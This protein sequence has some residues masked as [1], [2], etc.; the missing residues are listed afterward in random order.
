MRNKRTR[1]LILLLTIM[2][3]VAMI[4]M[5]AC[6]KKP[7]EDRDDPVPPPDKKMTFVQYMEKLNAG[8]KN[9]QANLAALKDYHVK[10]EYTLMT[11]EENL[12]LTYE[13]VYKTNKRD[14][15]YYIKLFDNEN[16]IDRLTMYYDAADLYVTAGERHYVINN[17][18]TLL[19]FETFA[20]A[21]DVLDMGNYAYGTEMQDIFSPNTVLSAVM[22]VKNMSYAKV[23]EKGERITASGI[24]L[25]VTMG[26]FNDR[27]AALNAMIG[28]TFD[29][30][31]DNYL[32]FRLSKMLI[33][34][35]KS[36]SV[37]EASFNLTNGDV[38]SE[39]IDI[40]GTID[41][42][43]Y[44]IKGEYAHDVVV[45]EIA[46]AKGLPDAYVY[47]KVSPGKGSLKGKTTIPELRES[48]FDFALDYDVVPSDN[49]KNKVTMRVYDDLSVSSGNVG[50]KKYDD[51]NEII[52]VY[53]KDALT[54]INTKGAYDFIGTTVALGALRLPK[55]YLK[56]FDLSG[57]LAVVYADLLRAADKMTI[58][59][60]INLGSKAFE[61]IINAVES[62]VEK[63]EIKVTVTE[64]LVRE[65]RGE[66]KSLLTIMSEQT[67]IDEE[68]LRQYLGDDFFRNMRVVITYNFG[69]KIV[70]VDVYD[71]TKLVIS[72]DLHTVENVGVIF[73]DDLNELNYTEFREPEL[74]TVEYEIE[75]NPYG[76]RNVS[77]SEFVGSFIGDA[78]GKNT[79]YIISEGHYVVAKGKMSERYVVGADGKKK[80]VT[81]LDME[82]FLEDKGKKTTTKFMSIVSDSDDLSK[83]FIELYTPVGDSKNERGIAYVMSK[84]EVARSLETLSENSIFAGKTGLSAFLAIYNAAE[85]NAK[86]YTTD[87]FFCVDLMVT[88]KKDPVNELVGI[89]NT[90]ARVKCK[91]GF[92]PLDLSGVEK[93]KYTTPVVHAPDDASATSIYS[94]GSKWKETVAVTVSDKRINMRVTYDPESI[95]IVT[96]KTEYNPVS[97][98]FGKEFGYALQ[99]VGTTGTYRVKNVIIDREIIDADKNRTPFLV[100]DPAFYSGVPKTIRVMFEGGE[101]G[102]LDCEIEGLEDANVTHD[103]YNL[104]LFAE[105]TDGIKKYKLV[106]GKDSIASIEKEIY[107]GVVNRTVKP[108]TDNN[109]NELRLVNGEEQIPVVAQ[110]VADPYTHAM[111]KRIRK[112]EEGKEYDYLAENI[113]LQN[114]MLDFESLYGY[115]SYDDGDGIKKRPLYYNRE[116]YNY[117]F[118]TELGLEWEF[119]NANELTDDYFYYGGETRYAVATYGDE[120]NG[121]GVKIAIKITVNQMEV[122]SVIIDN[123]ENTYV[124]DVLKTETYDI[125]TVTST[126]HTVKIKFND[127]R[128]TTRIVSLSRPAGISTER[129][130]TEYVYGSL[131]WAGR[132]KAKNRLNLNGVIGL[133]GEEGSQTTNTT[134]ATFGKELG[135]SVQ[136]VRLSVLA[137]RRTPDRVDE[138]DC[139]LVKSMSASGEPAIP[140]PANLNMVK[141]TEP[142]G[143]DKITEIDYFSINP[144]NKTARLPDRIWLYL[145]AGYDSG[146]K[147]PKEWVEYPVRWLTTDVSGKELNIIKKN[148]DGNFVLAHPRT[149]ETKLIVYGV[150]GNSEDSKRQIIISTALLNM[151]SNV[152]EYVLYLKNGGAQDK[153]EAVSID[154]YLSYEDVLPSRF[155]AKLG[156]GETVSGETEWYYGEFPVYRNSEYG[157]DYKDARYDKYYGKDGYYLFDRRGGQAELKMTVASGAVKNDIYVMVNVA[158]R[159]IKSERDGDVKIS[160]YID[161]FAT[162]KEDGEVYNGATTAGYPEI[163]Y[164]TQYSAALHARIARLIE[165]GGVGVAGFSFIQ[166]DDPK[167]LYAKEVRWDLGKLREIERGLT[168]K[169]KTTSFALTGTINS[170]TINETAISVLVSID[171]VTST[172]TEI[173]LVSGETMTSKGVYEIKNDEDN[174]GKITVVDG[175]EGKQLTNAAYYRADMYDAY[176]G[177]D[178]K[179]EYNTFENVLFFDVSEAFRLSRE[180]SGVYAAPSDYFEYLFRAVRLKFTSGKTIVANASASINYGGKDAAYFNKNVLGFGDVYY[181][182][183]RTLGYGF[184]I[185]ERFS[186]GS[187][188]DR[189]LVIVAADKSTVDDKQREDYIDALGE[190]LNELY[191]E[192]YNLPEKVTVGFRKEDGSTYN[193]TYAVKEWTPYRDYFSDDRAAKTSIPAEYINII[194]GVDY[195]FSYVLPDM[196]GANA[197]YNTFYYNVKFRKKNVRSIF[198]DGS[199]Q[200]S[201]YDIKE[202]KIN[203]DNT[204]TFLSYDPAATDEK[205]YVVNLSAI[206]TVVKMI[207]DV[208]N[209]QA[210]GSDIY[211][212]KWNFLDEEGNSRTA[213]DEKIF[214]QGT[215]ENGVL[216]ATYSF[217]S[218]YDSSRK[219]VTQTLELRLV[220]APMRFYAIADENFTVIAHQNEGE[221][222]LLNTIVIDP[223]NNTMGNNGTLTL[224]STLTLSFNAGQKFKFSN[225]SYGL[226]NAQGTYQK[227]IRTIGYNENGHK[228]DLAY[229]PDPTWLNLRVYVRGYSEEMGKNN[230]IRINI[231]FLK[232]NITDT[233]IPNSV[234]LSDGSFDYER[235]ANGNI[236]YNEN[237]PLKKTYNSYAKYA[238]SGS[239]FN[240]EGRMPVYFVDPYNSA[241]FALPTKALFEFASTEAGVYVEYGIS[242]WQYYNYSKSAYEDFEEFKEGKKP[243]SFTRFY[244]AVDD[245]N[246]NKRSY[247][248]PSTDSY[249][250]QTYALRGYVSVGDERQYFDVVMV[251]LNRSLRTSAILKD[252]YKVNYDFIDPIAAMLKDIPQLFGENAFVDY[253]R[254]TAKFSAGGRRTYGEGTYDFVLEEGGEFSRKDENGVAT[255]HAIV[256]EMLW[257]SEYD[258]DGDGIPDTLF[259]QLV[260]K[261]FVG[262]IDGNLYSHDTGI[263][264]LFKYYELK[265]DA[266]Y[267]RLASALL[268][269]ELFLANGSISSAYS[270]AARRAI[271]NEAAELEKEVIF[272]TY[273]IVVAK[274]GTSDEIAAG[275]ALSEDDKYAL[276]TTVIDAILQIINKED[277][278]LYDKNK[279]EDMKYLAYRT[280]LATKDS[281][282][283]WTETNGDKDIRVRIYEAW[284]AC[285]KEYRAADVKNS[286]NISANQKAKAEHFLKIYN[287]EGAFNTAEK[288]ALDAKKK[289]IMASL[290]VNRNSALWDE[291]YFAANPVER[292]MM[293]RYEKEYQTTDDDGRSGKSMASDFF[294]RDVSSLSDIGTK[295]E[296][297]EAD[298]SIP[299]IKYSSIEVTG[300]GT[301]IRFNKFNFQSIDKTFTVRFELSYDEIYKRMLEEAEEAVRSS[302]REEMKSEVLGEYEIQAIKDRVNA[303]APKKTDKDGNYYIIDG[304]KNKG[305]K[306]FDYDMWIKG[307]DKDEYRDFW[308][309]LIKHYR[310]AA[311]SIIVRNVSVL[312][313]KGYDDIKEDATFGVSVP[314]WKAIT[315][316]FKEVSILSIA[317]GKIADVRGKF[318]FEKQADR[319][320]AVRYLATFVADGLKIT[321]GDA[322]VKLGLNAIYATDHEYEVTEEIWT[323]VKAKFRFEAFREIALNK[324]AYIEKN[325]DVEEEK[326]RN[327]AVRDLA[328]YLVESDVSV[329]K[330][331]EVYENTEK[332]K[333]ATT[334]ANTLLVTTS[335]DEG[336]KKAARAAASEVGSDE[337]E[338]GYAV[339]FSYSYPATVTDVMYDLLEATFGQSNEAFTDLCDRHSTKRKKK[340]IVAYLSKQSENSELRIAAETYFTFLT[341]YAKGKISPY[342]VMMKNPTGVGYAATSIETIENG[343]PTVNCL[344][345]YAEPNQTYLDAIKSKGSAIGMTEREITVAMKR[346]KLYD[347]LYSRASQQDKDNYYS[348]FEKES[349]YVA[350]NDA[351]ERLFSALEKNG[352]QGKEITAALVSFY[353]KENQKQN[354]LAY[355]AFCALV[356]KAIEVGTTDGKA[357]ET[358]VDEYV[359]ENEHKKSKELLDAIQAN[360]DESKKQSD[361]SVTGIGYISK[362]YYSGYFE[363]KGYLTINDYTD[364]YHDVPYLKEELDKILEKKGLAY[365]ETAKNAIAETYMKDTLLRS[366]AKYCASADATSRATIEEVVA[367]FTGRRIN[368]GDAET[369]FIALAA[370]NNLGAE[371]G[372]KIY[373]ALNERD[374][375]DRGEVEKIKERYYAEWLEEAR[376]AAKKNI[377]S[378]QTS[379]IEKN[380]AFN[381]EISRL[382]GL[383]NV[384][385]G[386]AEGTPLEGG[387]LDSAK[388]VATVKI[389]AQMLATAENNCIKYNAAYN[390][391]VKNALYSAAKTYAYDRMCEVKS[392]SGNYVYRAALE[393]IMATKTKEAAEGSGKQEFDER[394]FDEAEQSMLRDKMS[395]AKNAIN[396]AI[397]TALYAKTYDKI[398]LFS[399]TANEF[400]YKL[401]AFINNGATSDNAAAELFGTNLNGAD[402]M[403]GNTLNEYAAGQAVDPTGEARRIVNR[404]ADW[405]KAGTAAAS[406]YGVLGEEERAFIEQIYRQAYY[407]ANALAGGALTSALSAEVAYATM[408]TSIYLFL[409]DKDD[410]ESK[411]PA[412]YYSAGNE[413]EYKAFIV[414]LMLDG[415]L[416]NQKGHALT[417]AAARLNTVVTELALNDA[418]LLCEYTGTGTVVG[419][420]TLS[421]LVDV[422]ANVLIK[423]SGVIKTGEI[424]EEEIAEREKFYLGY[425]EKAVNYVEYTSVYGAEEYSHSDDLLASNPLHNYADKIYV[426]V[427]GKNLYGISRTDLEREDEFG[428]LSFGKYLEKANGD[429]S[430]ALELMTETRIVEVRDF[431]SEDHAEK[432]YVHVVYFDRLK[433]NEDNP[434]GSEGNNPYYDNCNVFI[435]NDGKTYRIVDVSGGYGYANALKATGLKYTLSDF[436][437]IDLYF[438][439]DE[440]NP[441][442]EPTRVDDKGDTVID[443]TDMTKYAKAMET[444]E[445]K[446]LLMLDALAPELPDKAYAIGYVKTGAAIDYAAGI[447]LGK[448]DITEY[449]QEFNKLVYKGIEAETD[450]AYVIKVR[451]AR[452][453]VYQKQG[454]IRVGYLDRNVQKVYLE[455]GAYIKGRAKPETSGEFVNMYSQYDETTG[456]ATSGKNVI[457]IDPTNV[458]LVLSEKKS[459]AMPTA[460]TVKCGEGEK[461]E[462]TD[463]VWDMSKVKFGLSGTDNKGIDMRVLEYRY[464]DGNGNTRKIEYDYAKFSVTMTTYDKDTGEEKRKDKYELS[465][466]DMIDWNTV[467]V[468]ENQSLQGIS[469][470]DTNNTIAE[471]TSSSS[472]DATSHSLEINP[473]YPEYPEKLQLTL[474]N[475]SKNI[476]LTQSDWA[477]DLTKLNNI[478]RGVATDYKFDASFY[479]L[480][481]EIKVKFKAMEITVPIGEMLDGGTIY[482]MRDG[483]DYGTQFKRNYGE[484][485]FNFAKEEEGKPN[486]QKVPVALKD[487]NKISKTETGIQQVKAVIGSTSV[488]AGIEANVK[489]NLRLIDLKNYAEYDGG[490]NNFVYYDYYSIPSDGSKKATGTGESPA[491]MGDTFLFV[492]SD[493]EKAAFNAESDALQ[494]D[495]I[496]ST[497]TVYA[498]YGIDKEADAKLAYDAN[499][500]RKRGLYFT[501]PMESYER[502][503]VSDVEFVT[504]ATGKKW[505]WTSKSKTSPDYVD[506]IYWKIGTPMKASDLPTIRDRITGKEIKLD[507]DLA[508]LNV[509]RANVEVPNHATTNDGAEILGYYM[510][511][512]G[513]WQSVRLRVYIEKI[514]ITD[515]I[516]GFTKADG[517]KNEGTTLEKEYNAQYYE[518]PFNAE[519]DD[520]AFLREDGTHAVIPAEN[521]V[522]EYMK[523]GTD[524]WSSEQL[525]LD[526]GTY[527]IRVRLRADDYNVYIEYDN[528]KLFTLTIKPYVVDMSKVKFVGEDANGAINVVY[529]ASNV[530]TV[531]EGLPAFTPAGWFTPGEKSRLY[532]NYVKDGMTEEEAKAEVYGVIYN[533]VAD[534]TK[535][536]LDAWYREGKAT[537]GYDRVG[538]EQ[539]I[540]IKAWIYDSK[541]DAGITLV[542]IQVR[543]TYYYGTEQLDYVP[544]DCGNYTVKVNLDKDNANYVE[545]EKSKNVTLRIERDENIRYAFATANLVYNGRVQNPEISDLHKDG[546]VPFGVK[547]T[548]RYVINGKLL[549]VLVEG[550]KDVSGNVVNKITVDSANTTV[551]NPTSGIKNAGAYICS[552]EIDGGNNYPDGKINDQPIGISAAK[553]FIDIAD[554]NKKYLSDVANLSEYVKVYD[555]DGNEQEEGIL[556][557]GDKLADLGIL[558]LSAA[559]AEGI[560]FGSYFKV[561]TY[562]TFIDGLASSSTAAT[563]YTELDSAQYGFN[564]YIYSKLALKSYDKEGSLYK[565]ADGNAA[566]ID[567]F[568]NYNIFVRTHE[569][570][571]GVKAAGIYKVEGEDG[572]DGVASNAELQEYIANLKDGDYKIV[573]LSSLIDA[574]GNVAA[575]DP[576]VID[577]AVR[578]KI[579]GYTKNGGISESGIDVRQIETKIKGIRVLKGIVELRIISI[580]SDASGNS[581]LFIGDEASAV[582]MYNCRITKSGNKTDNVTGVETSVNY[583]GSVYVE[584]TTIDNVSMA[585]NF[586]G[587]ALEVRESTIERNYNG[588][589]ISTSGNNVNIAETKFGNNIG[590]AITSVTGDLTIR[591]CRF[592]YNGIS[593]DLPVGTPI[594]TDIN[595]ANVYENNGDDSLYE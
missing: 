36:C 244:T 27:F 494:Y 24:N 121:S 577:K 376:G 325:N 238:F 161:I 503:D 189:T 283:R 580:E 302:Y 249:K 182:T 308:N 65:L 296:R 139:T 442:N 341:R 242:G 411:V 521:Y 105:K 540:K 71:G 5:I 539:D 37:K 122:K 251:V 351:T 173:E 348:V 529:G 241:T 40:R 29:A 516:I 435:A 63:K 396:L 365:G 100:I 338:V 178:K 167:V 267:G 188:L 259:E 561:G 57:F 98:L 12:T 579:V 514:N 556:L 200:T 311:I 522:V 253:D 380:A 176:F 576:I 295:G 291:V 483:G 374:D 333:R 53:Y 342:D 279:E 474:A 250:G 340:A 112:N 38:H 382:T 290:Y 431:V 92:D 410:E 349:S 211:T 472:A 457:Y 373:D 83:V 404:L 31:T 421:Q 452:G 525:P 507:W 429:Y 465:K 358:F 543:F 292:E 459:Y 66:D 430:L 451:E 495:F 490:Y 149:D 313:N 428:M 52:S 277:Q 375:F 568:G 41:E 162:G 248:N 352:E 386:K 285:I 473:Y 519:A 168:K 523:E 278:K 399:L 417:L 215:D 210:G 408:T 447:K 264:A 82:F 190:D 445:K 30:I 359:A 257:S 152:K 381:A 119:I 64:D 166:I 129:Y 90:N 213:F 117:M 154:P 125:P 440:S 77:L 510:I 113:V 270:D 475:G 181:E 198:F 287:K 306:A 391:T 158:S 584:K 130:C 143:K 497:V 89:K 590:T 272:A 567:L 424:T 95:K 281:Y 469:D 212:V 303:I 415:D 222:E 477:P 20:S 245:N 409:Q 456:N 86:T 330:L 193:S 563:T 134:T 271:Q 163:S 183:G 572:S 471:A 140:M 221:D 484:M 61:S 282:D 310:D 432:G 332:E 304:L 541:M 526:A 58:G 229:T 299:V 436:T 124:M 51:I 196:E 239:G 443:Y 261:G 54:Y 6:E 44:M 486:W 362:N 534:R 14:G 557:G 101:Y 480:G 413:D 357:Y 252:E 75:L 255:N 13:A 485:Y 56:N 232:R 412:D 331:E 225:V 464:V 280:Y 368:G 102:S 146:E 468:I 323:T 8:I 10:S 437:E 589:V 34:K 478:R 533:R 305:G 395:A 123:K 256:P 585:I 316:A 322:Y 219:K 97:K 367:T 1:L 558:R 334:L 230:G 42:S 301:T 294:R 49:K 48:D 43:K 441:Y 254:Y 284:T 70:K 455:T 419:S 141:F 32:G 453:T 128:E 115:E 28:T 496:G 366:I 235:D 99:I 231:K 132:E 369:E 25:E 552:V 378:T 530:F 276:T 513:I 72:T 79:P 120:K 385:S 226:L 263:K 564:G 206:P 137:P 96:G 498:T 346:M 60:K 150:V 426:K 33:F 337:P 159:T 318:D 207:A 199:G 466:D 460:M 372:I 418:K 131:E 528:D 108:V 389:R 22:G 449:S 204:Y 69:T 151:E 339:L 527:Y 186:E 492:D 433:W 560:T 21:I 481:Y 286:G 289:T 202:G 592:E 470:S 388:E 515:H 327:K 422:M 448:V 175:G 548:Y 35:L 195:T 155:E 549:V 156:S 73:P 135:M 509:N 203:V 273:K 170:D 547:V 246:T 450:D 575:Y 532:N 350:G 504:D 518:L 328:E 377:Q 387:T 4:A 258:T 354:N 237:R 405:W 88:E 142:E 93:E 502:S 578:L 427:T 324:L 208:Q 329:S 260:N 593:L 390:A 531:A 39:L 416:L 197:T 194:D 85:K 46:A 94:N 80:A 423:A 179:F 520:M 45:D 491:A 493:G 544:T 489:F 565:D 157:A 136:T 15:N 571:D 536:A 114:V 91:I 243:S 84:S 228:L 187:A 364:D 74:V 315:D 126:E 434:T 402:G 356:N 262:T 594:R 407:Q 347:T 454:D 553:V 583:K 317:D 361:S 240:E 542:E 398:T 506:A 300:G 588:I 393:E 177:P 236:I 467:L 274:T 446:N 500:T 401:Y 345:Y 104:A 344:L 586:V 535:D 573:Y 508:G 551:T 574:E 370:T 62:N 227:D 111:M 87:G 107:V 160:D 109:G 81:S 269:D 462:F 23:G 335:A 11:R 326:G 216:I 591:K 501:M 562:Y 164:Y 425:L 68:L 458:N 165:D 321:I 559:D 138:M 319:R 512:N 397:K 555:E 538:R 47:E 463:V 570:V 17:F 78:T 420:T 439:A 218:Y 461:I 582:S 320:Q 209:Y 275:S 312:T 16:G 343:L 309:A 438:D 214:R 363:G 118:L 247:F 180:S 153:D 224:P 220:L 233:R 59:G 145:P 103:G 265:K 569:F 26:R 268:W 133:F 336:M 392:E 537:F 581:A 414:G 314:E 360:Y 482:L 384:L 379:Q 511:K 499:G 488:T 9:G 191:P 545:G 293:S 217:D 298:V 371:L 546:T 566:V 394:K 7:S 479:Y 403:I 106:I 3:V 169:I 50:V 307:N 353:D 406:I 147:S 201:T 110:F 205:R 174:N 517:T 288:A 505:K 223:Y 587:G 55:V 595:N 144:Y 524:V 444:N 2:V 266:E 400:A 67:G 355:F 171:E 18:S 148:D 192:R 185:L 76:A 116:G 487:A 297:A 550:V 19:L 554:I 476:E 184:V 172:V 383:M 234:Y 127:D